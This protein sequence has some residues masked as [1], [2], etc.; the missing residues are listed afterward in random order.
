M[1]HHTRNDG[2]RDGELGDA[3]RGGVWGVRANCAS[4]PPDLSSKQRTKTVPPIT[5]RFMDNIDPPLKQEI[6]HI[7]KRQREP[8]IEH[9]R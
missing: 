3:G 7:T 2:Y 4:S 1:Y 6:F 9:D 5:D 8:H